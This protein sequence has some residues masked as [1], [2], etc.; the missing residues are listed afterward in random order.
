MGD[1]HQPQTLRLPGVNSSGRRIASTVRGCDGNTETSS[2][3]S[4]GTSSDVVACGLFSEDAALAVG[5]SPP[6]G[7]RWFRDSGGTRCC[8]KTM[9]RRG[10]VARTAP[11]IARG[12]YCRDAVEGPSHVQDEVH[13]AN[14]PAYNQALVWRGMRRAW[15]HRSG[16]RTCPS[17]PALG[18]SGSG[19]GEG[20]RT[21]RRAGQGSEAVLGCEILNRITA[22]GRPESYR[23]G[24]WERCGA[25]SC[26]SVT[27][28]AT[29]RRGVPSTPRR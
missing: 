29:T 6:V 27:I 28:R 11:D 16:R 14:W 18:R 22:L 19:L 10:R 15:C 20:L 9:R 12:P 23:I 7:T 26:G 21:R 17:R 4:C 25:A 8:M 5:V 3:E 13:V 1:D 2:V 24:R